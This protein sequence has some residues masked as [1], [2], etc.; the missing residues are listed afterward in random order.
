MKFI[1]PIL[2]IL[3][4]PLASATADICICNYFPPCLGSQTITDKD[5]MDSF[6]FLAG[7]PYNE[8]N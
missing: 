1:S 3:S 6:I 4:M 7:T 5:F 8:L 2:M